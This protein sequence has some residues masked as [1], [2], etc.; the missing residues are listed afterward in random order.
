MI[1]LGNFKH[2]IYDRYICTS[3]IVFFLLSY[4]QKFQMSNLHFLFTL[5]GVLN[6]SGSCMF[7]SIGSTRSMLKRW[8]LCNKRT[9]STKLEFILKSCYSCI[10]PLHTHSLM[11]NTQIQVSLVVPHHASS[12]C[13]HQMSFSIWHY[14]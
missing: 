1:L 8:E 5:N 9:F 14:T 11:P 4:P 6:V 2:N 12:F 7:V 13:L 10:H 3:S